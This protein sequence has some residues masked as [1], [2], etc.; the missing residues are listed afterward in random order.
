MKTMTKITK[1]PK[2]GEKVIVKSNRFGKK[3]IKCPNCSEKGLIIFK[4]KNAI[5]ITKK[6]LIAYTSTIFFLL[7]FLILILIPVI[8]GSMHFLV[9]L[10]GSMQPSINAGDVVVT[11]SE[12]P[13]NIEIDDVIT[14]KDAGSE[15][16]DRLV[17]HRV[18]DIKREGDQIYFQTKGDANENPDSELVSSSRLYGCVVF[19]IP[20]VGYIP[21]FVGQPIGFFLMIMIP[22]ALIITFEVR[23]IIKEVKKKNV[24]E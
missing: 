11:I 5:K 8:Q 17:T 3:E 16:A 9:V 20:F 6:K 21:H 2:C 12:K 7:C 1:C 19:T 14:F 10:S 13:Y 22:G 24:K 4:Q 15:N 18:V 23:N